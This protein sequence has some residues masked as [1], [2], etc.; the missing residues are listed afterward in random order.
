LNL[1]VGIDAKSR[2]TAI[3]V[4]G[5]PI[6]VVI[7]STK[8]AGSSALQSLICECTDG[9]HVEHTRHA[10][11]ETL[12]WT[13][14]ASILGRKQIRIP[15]S[16]VPIA[17]QAAL[18]DMHALLAANVPGYA[19]PS[20]STEL[21]FEG[22]SR[23]CVRFGP[24]FVE[25]SPHH[26]QQWAALELLIE[27]V[28]RLPEIDFRFVGLV[29]NPMDVLYSMWRLWRADPAK[30]QHQWRVAYENLRRFQREVASPLLVVRYEDLAADENAARQ[31]MEFL[32]R[33]VVPE[34]KSYIHARSLQRWKA[35]RWFG[36][37]IDRDVER[38]A[39]SFGYS[40]TDLSN[41]T[42][43]LWGMYRILSYLGPRSLS[44]RWRVL[45]RYVRNSLLP[46]KPTQTEKK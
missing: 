3:T 36:F 7:L 37:Q 30:H 33:P 12:Y 34:A 45:R 27:A 22:W 23:L 44:S 5:R 14:A 6:C 43:P 39:A 40:E 28:H 1:K 16:E 21:I 29:R 9:K 20:D 18:H 2:E 35:D 4:S 46:I 42:F 41:R 26:L 17:P 11:H 38:L 19:L 32:D 10:Q 15:D 31:L 13:K 25:K 8:S 24:L